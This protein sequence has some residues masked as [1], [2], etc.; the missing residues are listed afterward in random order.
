TAVQQGETPLTFDLGLLASFDPNPIDSKAYSQDL[1]SYLKQRSRNA[2][3]ALINNIFNL[4]VT[5]DIDHGPLATLPAIQTRL[6]REKPLPKPKPL[7][8]WEKF[9]KIKGI[10]NKKKDKMVFDE[11]TQTWVP[12]W[13]YKGA[14][15]KVEDQWIHVVK[16]GAEDDYSPAKAAAKERKDRKLKNEAQRLKNL[17]RANQAETKSSSA[18]GLG[19]GK[20]QSG[21]LGS[22]SASQV[23]KAAARQKR[24]AEL[25]ADVLRSRASTASMGKFDK[26]LEG[27]GKAK[28]IKRKFDPLEQDTG[29]ERQASMALL[30]KLG[31]GP[32]GLK[33]KANSVGQGD[34]ELVNTRKAVKF[35]SGGSGG[36]ALGRKQ[37]QGASGAK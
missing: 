21:A 5:R 14:N 9:A 2:T 33:K 29:A 4:K 11:D 10:Q 18:S 26:R 27:E 37:A 17:A 25:E 3:Q 13:G 23:A 34:S 20:S 16:A 24:K 30:S 32:G 7:T 31:T 12:S 19:D 28:G 22:G 8:K 6:P 36:V 1:E 15:K 35:A